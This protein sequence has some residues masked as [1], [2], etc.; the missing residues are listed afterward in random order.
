VVEEVQAD[1]CLVRFGQG[2]PKLI[3]TSHLERRSP[4]AARIDGERLFDAYLL[5][6]WS[7]SS[8]PSQGVNS[9][10][11]CLFE[12]GRRQLLRNVRTRHL[13]FQ[14]IRG[15]LVDLVTSGL[16][17]LVGFDFPYGYPAGTTKQLGFVEG[18]PWRLMWD[19]LLDLVEDQPNNKNNRFEVAAEL[20]GAMTTGPAPFWGCPPKEARPLLHAKKPK[21]WPSAIPEFRRVERV[22]GVAAGL[23]S[24]WQLLGA[25]AVGSQALVGIP[26]L[27]RLRDD[28]AVASVSSVW[29]FEGGIGAPFWPP[30]GQGFV[31]H[32]EIYPSL[33]PPSPL[34]P[35]K[36]AGQVR[37]LAEHFA[38]LDE[39]Q[40]LAQLFDL[41]SLGMDDLQAV[42]R[43]EGWI[44]G[45]RPDAAPE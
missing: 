20:N 38:R 8:S 40:G 30:A 11:Y 26:W 17:V 29:P 39:E 7:A 45:I 44:L 32:S 10:W 22:E 24:P 12:P 43:E 25:G 6:D 37:A 3:L 14:E 31:L 1:A 28:E 4:R 2:K 34:E 27:A 35:V 36:D 41:T 19:Q 42:V 15:H 18:E 16:R 21:P 33:V 9:I 23:K 13:A 5:M